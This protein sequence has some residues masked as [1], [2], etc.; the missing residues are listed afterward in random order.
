V[1][2]G[3]FARFVAYL[4]AWLLVLGIG[5]VAW[6]SWSGGIGLDLYHQGARWLIGAGL[7]VPPL[8]AAL[9]RTRR[10]AG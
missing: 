9:V 6:V 2:P 10:R 4:G 7:V 8:I 1:I 3:T 5:L